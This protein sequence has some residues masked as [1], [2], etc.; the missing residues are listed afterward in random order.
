MKIIFGEK[1]RVFVCRGDRESEGFWKKEKE[2]REIL[3][4]RNFLQFYFISGKDS[5]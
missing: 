1:A 4:T 3:F 5:F 2:K